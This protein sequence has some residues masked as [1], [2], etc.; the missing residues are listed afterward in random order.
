MQRL[1]NTDT[2]LVRCMKYIDIK[3]VRAGVVKHPGE[4]L[5][6]GYYE[7]QSSAN[8]YQVIDQQPSLLSACRAEA[9]NRPLS[10]IASPM[11]P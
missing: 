9:L 1:Y 8:D 6:S 11:R 5:W 3:I 7:I 10:T 4:W 2:Q